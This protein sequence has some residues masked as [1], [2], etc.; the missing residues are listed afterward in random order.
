MVE[1]HAGNG[2]GL[3]L[4]ALPVNSEPACD[5][6]QL[7]CT[8]IGLGTLGR[9]LAFQL[10]HLGA[11][12]LQLIDGATVDIAHAAAQGYSLMEVGCPVVDALA[13]RL[14]A[15]KPDIE[16]LVI[17]DHWR[18]VDAVSPVI[19]CADVSVAARVEIW[20]HVSWR[21]EFWVDGR[22]NLRAIQLS[23]VT[24]AAARLAYEASLSA[25]Q[26][27]GAGCGACDPLTVYAFTAAGMMAE[28]W[29]RWLNRQPIDDEVIFDL[30]TGELVVRAP[31]NLN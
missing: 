12:R 15:A 19:F 22:V 21:T 18:P 7:H 9:H 4:F 27:Q 5:R 8:I 11:R 29:A 20:R 31:S 30:A 10:L 3:D 17:R 24:S 2:N 28:Q 6:R 23:I 25:I 14:R 16:I 13:H 26:P 1:D